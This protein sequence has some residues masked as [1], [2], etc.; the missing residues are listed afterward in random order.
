MRSLPKRNLLILNGLAFPAAET[1]RA[2]NVQTLWEIV[3]NRCWRLDTLEYRQSILSCNQDIETMTAVL[4][5]SEL[6]SV[7]AGLMRC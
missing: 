7:Y 3:W 4:P 5:R 1:A 6:A 2:G